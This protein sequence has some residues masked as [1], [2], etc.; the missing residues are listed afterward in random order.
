LQSSANV[1]ENGSWGIV[2]RLL[3]TRQQRLDARM[4]AQWI[5]ERIDA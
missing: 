2:E 1:R 5:V 3:V 4:I